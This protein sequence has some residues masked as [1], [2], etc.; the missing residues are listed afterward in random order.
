M[1]ER[2]MLTPKQAAEYVGISLSM[3]YQLAEERR[4]THFRVGGKG[5]RGKLLFLPGDLDDFLASCRVTEP[6]D[7]D[8][9]L[10]HIR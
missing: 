3:I 1:S 8:G 4:I 2:K 6:P 5:K 7:E 9:P 10:V